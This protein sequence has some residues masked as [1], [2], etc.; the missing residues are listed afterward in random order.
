MDTIVTTAVGLR[1]DYCP[2]SNSF[3][4]TNTDLGPGQQSMSQQRMENLDF[5]A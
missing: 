3:T 2:C 1:T 5:R 4:V